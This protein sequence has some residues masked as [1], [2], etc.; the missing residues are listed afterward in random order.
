MQN[1]D[2]TL[3]L[4]CKRPSLG[5][6]K[7]RLA[8]DTNPTTAFKV[9]TA[10]HSCAMEDFN[11]WHGPKILSPSSPA[12]EIW[13]STM[14]HSQVEIISQPLEGNLGQKIQQVDLNARNAGHQTTII[15]GSDCPS[16]TPDIFHAVIPL[17]INADIVLGPAMDGG[18]Y[19]MASK[20]PW[21]DL[22]NLPWSTR[23]LREEIFA[24]CQSKGLTVACLPM[25]SDVDHLSD[26]LAVKSHL[27]LRMSPARKNLVSLIEQVAEEQGTKSH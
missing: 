15:I 27:Q 5:V 8:K 16:I 18:V 1:T 12:D 26:L 3:I 23:T 21:P 14:T 20:Q 11:G 7:Q 13:A 22:Q 17:L 19:L 10:L 6:G 4:F 9:A 2:P 24:L 25:F